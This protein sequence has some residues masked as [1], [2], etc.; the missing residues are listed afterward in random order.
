MDLCI[1]ASHLCP[2]RTFNPQME[3]FLFSEGMVSFLDDHLRPNDLLDKE[4]E[5]PTCTAAV[6]MKHSSKSIE[7]EKSKIDSTNTQVDGVMSSSFLA[8]LID[9]M[10]D[11]T[12]TKS[13]L[14]TTN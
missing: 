4:N 2:L 9:E 6:R 14:L 5:L 12:G 7:N 10:R 13:C 8:V 11:N 1:S 3:D